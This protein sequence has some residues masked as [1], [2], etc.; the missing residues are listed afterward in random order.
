LKKK[1]KGRRSFETPV[2][3]TAG[4]PVLTGAV[5]VKRNKGDA[6]VTVFLEN[7]KAGGMKKDEDR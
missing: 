2:T 1:R 4:N 7:G 3:P 5:S 6:K